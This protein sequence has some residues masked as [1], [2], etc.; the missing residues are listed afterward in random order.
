MTRLLTVCVLL[1]GMTAAT[2][3]TGADA[4]GGRAQRVEDFGVRAFRK[5]YFAALTVT[6][7][8][9]DKTIT[10]G[11][12]HSRIT[13]TGEGPDF[14]KAWAADGVEFVAYR[15]HKNPVET[16]PESFFPA[17]LGSRYARVVRVIDERNLIVNFEF[18]GGSP[19]APKV[20]E[21]ASGYFFIDCAPALRKMVSAPDRPDVCLFES[22]ACYVSKGMPNIPFVATE[23]TRN[24]S[25]RATKAG[26]RARIKLSAEDAIG[27]R[28]RKADA[29]IPDGA[30]FALDAHDR[31]IYIED[32][33]IIGPTYSVPVVESGW[34]GVMFS[35]LNGQCAR[36]ME[37]RNCNTFAEKAEFEK[38]AAVPAG[39]TWVAPGI[40]GIVGGGGKRGDRGDGVVDILGYQRFNLIR[41]TWV[42]RCIHSIKNNDGAGNWITID[43]VDLDADGRPVNM[44]YEAMYVKR[45]RFENVLISFHNLPG[46]NARRGMRAESPD[47]SWHMLA[48]QYWTG[49]TSTGPADIVLIDIDG[50]RLY[51]GNNGDWWREAQKPGAAGG[52][53]T[54]AEALLFDRIPVPGDRVPL[55]RTAEGAWRTWGWGVQIGDVLTVAGRDLA[56]AARKRLSS[57][58]PVLGIAMPAKTTGH[59]HYWELTFKDKATPAGDKAEAVVKTSRTAHLLD[60]KPR[61]ATL[62]YDRDLHGHWQYNRAEVN[63]EFRNI[64]FNGYYRQTAGPAR[65]QGDYEGLWELPVTQDWVNCRAMD[66][67]GSVRGTPATQIGSEAFSKS[68]L[69]LR[70]KHPQS[71]K[72]DH[73]VLVDGGR[74]YAGRLNSN[75]S[76][77][78][79]RNRPTLIYGTASFGEPRL[80]NPVMLDDKGV[81]CPAGMSLSLVGGC[82]VNLSHSIIGD[83][84]GKS[85]QGLY[86]YGNGTLIL[87]DLRLFEVPHGKQNV[88]GAVSTT[89]ANGLQKDRFALHIRGAGGTA[90]FK[91]EGTPEDGSVVLK[92]WTFLQPVFAKQKFN[93]S[94]GWQA[95]PG[96]AEK[97]TIDGRPGGKP[98][99]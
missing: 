92:D 21:R 51:P 71:R 64:C 22:G 34:D 58:D 17:V 41:S 16:T 74:L 36:T 54:A 57:P 24:M 72:R 78:W 43:G 29:A 44:A 26:T 55:E 4:A 96:F 60:G 39:A 38:R 11:A 69:E 7:F 6:P 32:I 18:N 31:S 56:V 90:G 61:A 23:Q 80:C 62:I 76:P 88:S 91:L 53:L 50:F 63:Y 75:L 73:H 30:F 14:D 84:N 94:P 70:N 9:C 19:D 82:T 1:A 20:S 8:A 98:W 81:V 86:V 93:V 85:P 52:I 25:W 10:E 67:D 47:F 59:A 33:D 12:G 37:I 35:Y 13:R 49:G 66:T 3:V 28:S 77:V 95:L 2:E 83:P 89:L 45:N 65:N 48:N 79:I 15:I 99:P 5:D 97:V 46:A 40:T 27:F 68:V 87:D 42:A